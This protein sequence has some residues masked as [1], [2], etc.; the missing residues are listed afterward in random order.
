[1]WAK[2]TS[3]FPPE[4]LEN[5]NS[6]YSDHLYVHVYI[7]MAEGIGVEIYWMEIIDIAST[8]PFVSGKL[9]VRKTNKSPWNVDTARHIIVKRIG[10]RDKT[11]LFLLA[12]WSMFTIIF[13]TDVWAAV[14]NSRIECFPSFICVRTWNFIE[15]HS[16]FP[17]K[18][19]SV[20]EYTAA[21][22]PK[23]H[24]TYQL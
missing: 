19:I 4:R 13:V 11:S 21:R 14:N 2:K 1:M 22:P 5:S 23:R 7:T 3:F 12:I 18:G 17:V 24:W 8:P 6:L 15:V 20:N 9:R 10:I 16:R